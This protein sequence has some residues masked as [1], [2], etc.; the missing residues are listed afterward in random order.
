[1]QFDKGEANV[2]ATD[3]LFHFPAGKKA[4]PAGK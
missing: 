2:D 1:V 4:A 3:G